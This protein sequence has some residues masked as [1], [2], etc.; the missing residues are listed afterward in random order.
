MTEEYPETLDPN[1]RQ[2]S[3][4]LFHNL[5]IVLEH[6]SKHQSQKKYIL[7]ILQSLGHYNIVFV[8]RLGF[9]LNETEAQLTNEFS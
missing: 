5:D 1:D 6:N 4:V 9:L 7:M 2:K 3:G 8:Y